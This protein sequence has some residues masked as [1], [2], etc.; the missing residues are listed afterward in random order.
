MVV[1]TPL[2]LVL[3]RYRQED[4]YEFKTTLIY[5]EFQASQEYTVGPYLKI[6]K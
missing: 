5:I 1:C 3:R 4:L 2:T 6:N